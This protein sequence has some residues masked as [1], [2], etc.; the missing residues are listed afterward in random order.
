MKI[1]PRPNVIVL[2]LYEPPK[3]SEGG[4]IIPDN[5][6]QPNT[7]KIGT[8]THVG[9]DIDFLTVGDIVAFSPAYVNV[10]AFS[11][12]DIKIFAKEENILAI[13]S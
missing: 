5:A 3:E 4:I 12:D 13:L 9:E 10:I 7:N 6:Q 8:I 2:E 1:E 11:Q